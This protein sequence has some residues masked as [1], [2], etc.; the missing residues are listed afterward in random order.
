MTAQLLNEY[1]PRSVSG[2]Q[3]RLNGSG[4]LSIE[5]LKN[6]SLTPHAEMRKFVISAVS[7]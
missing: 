2:L 5:F 3:E 1:I 6:D 4:L 7:K